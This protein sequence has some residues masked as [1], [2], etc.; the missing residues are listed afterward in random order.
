MNFYGE[1]ILSNEFIARECGSY[2]DYL[3]KKCTEHAK[4]IFGEE[5]DRTLR[6]VFYFRTNS[7][8]PFAVGEQ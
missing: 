3:G 5:V 8:S 4:A 6:G 7:E 1:S 2:D